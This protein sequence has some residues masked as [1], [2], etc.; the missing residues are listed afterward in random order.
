MPEPER[1]LDPAL[2]ARIAALERTGATTDFDLRSWVWM[3][4]LGIAL[5]VALILL[6]WWA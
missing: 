4:L 6:G 5:P 1:E 3:V 2:E